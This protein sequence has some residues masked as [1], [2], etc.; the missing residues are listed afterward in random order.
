MYVPF[1]A[2]NRLGCKMLDMP[3]AASRYPEMSGLPARG[4]ACI[5]VPCKASPVF[6]ASPHLS[7]SH[8]S[9]LSCKKA[10]V[11]L[12]R[13]ITHGGPVFRD[14]PTCPGLPL[15]YLALCPSG[16]RPL[17]LSRASLACCC[18]LGGDVLLSPSFRVTAQRLAAG[19]TVTQSLP[20]RWS[21]YSPVRW[22]FCPF[23]PCSRDVSD[24]GKKSKHSWRQ[25]HACG[26]IMLYSL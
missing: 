16:S 7:P 23:C 12:S 19:F 5:C 17:P 8:S 2:C 4:L 21:N 15:I 22:L 26:I 13:E 18:R 20:L 10:A 6:D 11:T 14:L 25:W 1:C 3:P 9:Q 24:S